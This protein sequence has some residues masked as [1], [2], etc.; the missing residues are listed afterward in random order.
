M[1]K[2]CV[3]ALLGCGDYVGFDVLGGLVRGMVSDDGG[4]EEGFEFRVVAGGEF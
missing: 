1:G 3:T 2:I 4:V